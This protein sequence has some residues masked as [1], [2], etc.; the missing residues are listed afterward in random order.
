MGQIPLASVP[1]TNAPM[2]GVAV[3]NSA[4][5]WPGAEGDPC[6]RSSTPS[7]GSG[8]SSTCSTGVAARLTL[9][10]RPVV[11][12]SSRLS[13][14]VLSQKT[15]ASGSASIG[16][17]RRRAPL[18]G[19]SRLRRRT[20]C[21]SETLRLPGHD[22]HYFLPVFARLRCILAC[23]KLRDE[24]AL[25]SLKWTPSNERYRGRF[26]IDG[27]I[28]HERRPHRLKPITKVRVFAPPSP[29]YGR[30]EYRIERRCYVRL[31]V[32]RI[33]LAEPKYPL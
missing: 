13:A 3:E 22:N 12:G 11:H 2:L 4:A 29:A 28:A 26:Q 23:L 21:D 9:L 18:R 17:S 24:A 33:I 25:T 6:C 14:K 31:P 7:L 27:C 8:V 30:L 1:V 16:Q 15:N 5:A 20:V 32:N 10:S 19:L